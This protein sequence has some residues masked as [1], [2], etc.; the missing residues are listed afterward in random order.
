MR[1]AA[2][3]LLF[4]CGCVGPD[5]VRPEMALGPRTTRETLPAQTGSADVAVGDA[6]RFDEKA[7]I[8][9]E[10]WHLFRSPAL[11]RLIRQA[12]DHSPTLAAAQASLRQAEEQAKAQFGQYFPQ[13]SGSFSPSWN[14]TALGAVSAASASGNPDYS[15]FTLQGAVSFVPD[16]F[17]ANARAV[18]SAEAQAE[19]QRFQMEATFV[20]LTSNVVVA[21]IQEA[22][23]NAQVGLTQA[24]TDQVTAVYALRQAEQAYLYAVGAN[25]P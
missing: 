11:D 6:Q 9:A 14:H 10:W 15:L 8:P 17:G 19:N 20:T 23:L 5:Y 4:L 12:I 13:I 25:T 22:N 1:E 18:E 7:D 16:V 3:I 2:L 21:A 24:L